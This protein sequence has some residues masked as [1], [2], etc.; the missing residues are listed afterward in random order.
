M[1]EVLRLVNPPFST[2]AMMW[3]AAALF[4]WGKKPLKSQISLQQK[5]QAMPDIIMQ[6]CR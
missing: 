4:I 2:K 3:S 1:L 6:I 5:S